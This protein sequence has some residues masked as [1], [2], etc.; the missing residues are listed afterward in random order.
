M[1]FVTA[2]LTFVFITIMIDVFILLS[3]LITMIMIINHIF[4]KSV[5]KDDYIILIFNAYILFFMII[6]AL[7]ITLFCCKTIF[8]QLYDYDF[9]SSWCTCSG[10]IFIADLFVLYNTFTTQVNIFHR[11]T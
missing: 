5:K 1:G 11:I 3:S 6:A 8:G 2:D 4:T 7:L 9:R 10:Y